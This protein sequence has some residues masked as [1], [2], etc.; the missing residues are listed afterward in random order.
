ME[1]LWRSR[2]ESA[3]KLH[4]ISHRFFLTSPSNFHMAAA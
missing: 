3:Q 2:E 4:P 1:I